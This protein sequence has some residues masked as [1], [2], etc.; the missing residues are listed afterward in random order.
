MSITDSE[1]ALD[2]MLEKQ[3]VTWGEERVRNLGATVEALMH[4]RGYSTK[5][6]DSLAQ[7]DFELAA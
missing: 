3:K 5:E 6:F 7:D 4:R 1:T 2:A